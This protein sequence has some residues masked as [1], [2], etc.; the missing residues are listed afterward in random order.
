M[1]ASRGTGAWTVDGLC[2]LAHARILAGLH[3]H[4]DTHIVFGLQSLVGGGGGVM[5]AWWW[6]WWWCGGEV[7]VVWW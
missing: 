6:W 1:A 5:V 3:L 4:T 7:V 2:L